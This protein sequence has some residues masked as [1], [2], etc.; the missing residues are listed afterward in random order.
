V[1][2][3]VLL[4]VVAAAVRV[5]AAA[6]ALSGDGAVEDVQHVQPVLDHRENAGVAEDP[7]VPGLAPA[8]G[9]ESRTVEN[10]RRTARVL[11]TPEH[12]GVELQQIGI[13]PVQ[14]LGHPLSERT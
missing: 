7:G 9:V 13:L 4:H 3:V 11:A 8:L 2:A 5:D 12:R 1:L 10:D 6:H 14:P